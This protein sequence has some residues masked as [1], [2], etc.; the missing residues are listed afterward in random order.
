MAEKEIGRREFMTEVGMTVAGTSLLLNQ[1]AARPAFAQKKPA[2]T[3]KRTPAMEYRPLGKTGLK[4]SAVGFGVMRLKEPAVLF[5]ALDSGI[6]Y[7]DTA[8]NYQNGNNEKMLGNAVKEYGRKK[9]IIGTKIHP[10]HMSQEATGAPGDFHLRDKKTMLEMVD[11]CLKRLQTDYIDVLYIHNIM[12]ESWPMNEDVLAVLE[13]VKKDGKARFAGLSIHDPRF[14]VNVVDQA[15]KS[16]IYEV[17]TAWFNY[18]SPPEY[19][20]ALSRASKAGLGIVAMKTQM[21]GYEPEPGSGLSPQQAVL[22]WALDQDFV[23]TTIPGMTNN[24]Q[25][26]ENVGAVGKKVGWSDRKTLHSYYDSIKNRYCTM[27]G[28]CFGTCRYR[29]EIN[30]INR[31]LMYCEGYRDFEQARDTY[32]ALS[33][34]ANA[35]ACMSCSSPTCGCANGMKIAQRMRYAHSLLG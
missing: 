24:E 9:A 32:A 12:N 11:N 29:V 14:F 23:N 33:K 10:F 35:L 31:A 34:K 17:I 19:G 4:V 3:K 18:K 28:K 25:V 20:E 8:D 15:A 6:N 13:K 5:K 16:G 21:G 2:A 26:V 27:C 1:F 7:F 30:T 22:K